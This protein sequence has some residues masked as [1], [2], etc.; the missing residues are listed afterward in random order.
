MHSKT[1][2]TVQRISALTCRI[3]CIQGNVCV[4]VFNGILQLYAVE[5]GYNDVGLSGTSYITPDAL[6]YQL[7]PH[8]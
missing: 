3:T 4:S 5:P 8:F 6:L 7:I 2:I 1:T